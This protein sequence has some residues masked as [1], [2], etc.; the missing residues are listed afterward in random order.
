MRHFLSTPVKNNVFREILEDAQYK[1]N[2][3]APH[4][5]FLFMPSF[6]VL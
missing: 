4:A 6:G 5:A 2:F 1:P 3:N